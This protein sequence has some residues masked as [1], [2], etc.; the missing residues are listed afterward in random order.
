MEFECL[1]VMRLELCGH[2]ALRRSEEYKENHLSK[3]KE[4]LG[5]QWAK[6]ETVQNLNSFNF[7]HLKM[8]L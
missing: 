8:C 2:R 7:I 5:E 6:L 1:S 3:G 4:K